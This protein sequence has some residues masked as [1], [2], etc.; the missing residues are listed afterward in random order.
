MRSLSGAF[1]FIYWYCERR[2]LIRLG[3]AACPSCGNLFGVI[4]ARDAKRRYNEECTQVYED[5]VR[6][7]GDCILIDFDG[8]WEV[9]CP[10]CHLATTFDSLNGT[11]EHA[12]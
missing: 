8:R 11:F 5:L 4:A 2:E 3:R 7:H 1:D 9:V 10:H 12:G 6:E